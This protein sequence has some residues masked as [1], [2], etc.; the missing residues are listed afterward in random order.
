MQLFSALSTTEQKKTLTLLRVL[1]NKVGTNII[2]LTKPIEGLL[3]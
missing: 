1:E 3:F 2:F